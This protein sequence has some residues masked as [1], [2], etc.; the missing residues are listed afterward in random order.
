VR[1]TDNGVLPLS[2]AVT[3]AVVVASRPQITSVLPNLSGG[4]SLTF[5]TV[6]D[7]TYRV[8]FKDSPSDPEWQAL[9][10]GT[11]ATGKSLTI[12]DKL[13]SQP[14]RFYRMVVLD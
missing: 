14:E 3:F 13:G 9:T 1:V 8:D 11:V 4:C 10:P 2:A 12:T 7:K 6:P 5:E